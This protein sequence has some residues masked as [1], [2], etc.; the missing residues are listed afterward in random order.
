MNAILPGFIDTP[1]AQAV[2]DKVKEKIYPQIPLGRFG[3]PDDIAD[4]VVFLS[5]DRSKYITGAVIEVT[6]GYNM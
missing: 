3:E 6:G 1:M 4:L 2:P 5:S